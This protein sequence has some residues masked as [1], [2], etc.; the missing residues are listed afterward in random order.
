MC[1]ALLSSREQKVLLVNPGLGDKLLYGATD[2]LLGAYVPPEEEGQAQPALWEEATGED[3][4]RGVRLIVRHGK[5]GAQGQ[6]GIAFSRQAGRLGGEINYHHA[7]SGQ[8]AG[9][10]TDSGRSGR[11]REGSPL[12]ACVCACTR[13][14]PPGLPPQPLKQVT[15]H[16]KG[17]YFATVMSDNSHLQVLIHQASKR[18]SQA[19]FRQSKGQVQRVLFHPLRPFF[20]V[21]TQ[22]FVRVYNL[23]KQ[24]LTKKLLTNCQWV[25]S[26]AVHPGGRLGARAAVGK[27]EPAPEGCLPSAGTVR[28]QALGGGRVQVAL[29]AV[30]G[31]SGFKEIGHWF[32]PGGLCHFG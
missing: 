21:A 30:T 15:W 29:C 6:Q 25:S 8:R 27:Q 19:P 28:G 7:T 10:E 23:L 1:F 9:N 17:D 18:W 12:L 31:K 20:F 26:M 24:E 2:Q 14:D 3:H 11:K 5:V 32:L 22:R 4:S 16:G 13:A